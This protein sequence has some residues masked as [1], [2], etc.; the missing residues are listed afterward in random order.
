MSTFSE[1]IIRNIDFSMSLE[2]MPLTEENKKE[3]QMCLDGKIDLK[4]LISETISKYKE[5]AI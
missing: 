5:T 3:M 1:Y 2:D 4:N